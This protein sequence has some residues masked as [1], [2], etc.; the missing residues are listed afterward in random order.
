M[1]RSGASPVRN[2]SQLS[3]RGGRCAA[4]A[5]DDDDDDGAE[6]DAD[7]DDDDDDDDDAGFAAAI[8]EVTVEL[9]TTMVTSDGVASAYTGG[10]GT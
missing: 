6:D 7:D 8:G 1:K 3:S 2:S 9:S 10:T 5:A 4:V